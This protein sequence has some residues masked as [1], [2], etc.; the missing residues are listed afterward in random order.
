CAAGLV[1]LARALSRAQLRRMTPLLVLAPLAPLAYAGGFCLG[2]PQRGVLDITYYLYTFGLLLLVFIYALVDWD[3]MRGPARLAAGGVLV[4][5]ALLH[6]AGAHSTARAI[7]RANDDAST[8]LTRVERFVD[9]HRHEPDFTFS[10]PAHPRTVDPEITLKAGY[11]DDP[12]G[13]ARMKH[14]TEILFARYYREDNPK[15]RF[16]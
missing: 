5:F 11:P 4:A 7:G 13:A 2:R 12:A 1:V 16:N 8:F 3:A 10:V 15:Y 6:G 14:L 9:Q